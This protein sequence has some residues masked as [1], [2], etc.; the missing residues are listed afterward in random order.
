MGA[1]YMRKAGGV[2][3]PVLLV[4]LLACAGGGCGGD[5]KP[6]PMAVELPVEGVDA[7][8]L[9]ASPRGEGMPLVLFLPG[10]ANGNAREDF[11]GLAAILVPR[12]Y[13][14]AAPLIMGKEGG[15]LRSGSFED[16][17]RG[18][19]KL[20]KAL[21][22]DK[23]VDL[24]RLALVAAADDR[25]VAAHVATRLRSAVRALVLVGAPTSTLL[26]ERIP[27]GCTGRERAALEARF[28]K[29]AFSAT[30]SRPVDG[31]TAS[32]WK[33]R[34]ERALPMEMKGVSA[35]TLV[36]RSGRSPDGAGRIAFLRRSLRI[37]GGPDV[38]EGVL[39]ELD[40]ELRDGGG[41]RRF[42]AVARAAFS[43]LWTHCPPP[44]VRDE[45]S[46]SMPLQERK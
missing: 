18:V 17:V 46:G 26:D 37:I 1:M 24:R 3:L 29:A 35:P 33:E 36:L 14:V 13:A 25:W 19:A 5:G 39:D 15:G 42:E 41:R 16:R 22:A 28:R 20:L 43:I 27:G 11:E 34:L 40:G 8:V 44:P 12:G 38:E 4:F 21:R 10:E 31:A 6:R 30:P 7:P 2:L 9:W 23:G 32:W 45:R